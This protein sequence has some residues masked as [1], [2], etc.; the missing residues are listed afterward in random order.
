KPKVSIEIV[1]RRCCVSAALLDEANNRLKAR[2]P[3]REVICCGAFN[4]GSLWTEALTHIREELIAI[5]KQRLVASPRLPLG[6]TEDRANTR[7]PGA[8]YRR[9]HWGWWVCG[10]Q[11]FTKFHRKINNLFWLKDAGP[12]KYRLHCPN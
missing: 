12:S 6:R 1:D 5:N 4:P 10:N 8:I 3:A 11:R 9:N 2:T 7:I